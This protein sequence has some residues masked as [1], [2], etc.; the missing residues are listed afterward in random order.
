M[1]CYTNKKGVGWP[2]G[3]RKRRARIKTE[4]QKEKLDGTET[5]KIAGTDHHAQDTER[6]TQPGTGRKQRA[7]L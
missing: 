3:S 6:T 7:Q 1:E 4:H 5:Q 2:S